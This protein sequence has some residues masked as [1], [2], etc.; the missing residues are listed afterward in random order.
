MHFDRRYRLH[1][2]D[3]IAIEI[4]GKDVAACAEDD[5]APGGGA[6]APHPARSAASSTARSVRGLFTRRSRRNSTGSRPAAVASSSRADS[7][8]N[9]VCELP[10]ERQTMI[11]TPASRLVASTLKFW[12]VYGLFTAPITVMTSTPSLNKKS[13]RNGRLGEVG[14]AASCWW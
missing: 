10:T 13:P 6:Q 2:H 12:N 4:L 8:A 3:W 14:S 5:L 1:A 11:G 7:R 9:S